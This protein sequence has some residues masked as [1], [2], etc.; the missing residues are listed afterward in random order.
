MGADCEVVDAY[1][2][3]ATAVLEPPLAL[4]AEGYEY[5]CGLHGDVPLEKAAE[6]PC[7]A[8]SFICRAWP[9]TRWSAASPNSWREVGGA[10]LL[11][12]VVCTNGKHAPNP[13]RMASV[14]ESWRQPVI[15]PISTL[16]Q[17][18]PIAAQGVSV[19]TG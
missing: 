10:H 14:D 12:E 1:T 2:G 4:P 19:A 3:Y 15:S 13:F 7:S 8:A 18:K 16:P 17:L 11:L 9:A 6:S 5:G